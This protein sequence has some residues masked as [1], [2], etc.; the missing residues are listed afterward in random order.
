M[1]H[2]RGQDTQAD[3]LIGLQQLIVMLPGN[4]FQLFFQFHAVGNIDDIGDHFYGDLP[5]IPGYIVCFYFK[6][7]AFPGF[8]LCGLGPFQFQGPSND[9]LFRYVFPGKK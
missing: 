9:A 7:P 2:T 4:G 5:R 3:H 1:G 6:N 8:D